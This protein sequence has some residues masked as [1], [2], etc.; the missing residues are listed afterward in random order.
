MSGKTA[1]CIIIIIACVNLMLLSW[2][3]VIFVANVRIAGSFIIT[4]LVI[5][6]SVAAI[7]QKNE[8]R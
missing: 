5:F 1:A 2:W 3:S 4:L 8:T 6:F 7:N